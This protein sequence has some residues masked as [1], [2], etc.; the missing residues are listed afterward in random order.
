MINKESRQVVRAR[1]HERVRAKISGT[2]E[3]PRLSVYRANANIHAQ[4]IDDV[5]GV[6]LVSASSICCGSTSILCFKSPS[7]PTAV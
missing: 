5:K 7:S 3:T 4:I 1:R 2:A 6:T